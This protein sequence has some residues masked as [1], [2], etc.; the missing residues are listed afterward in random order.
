MDLT[1]LD[2]GANEGEEIRVG[3]AFWATKT[4]PVGTVLEAC[5][6]G[7]SFT[8]S[9]EEWFA[10]LVSELL[11]TERPGIWV[12][13]RVLGAESDGLLKSATDALAS[14]YLHLCSEDPCPLAEDED[15]SIH[16]TRMR[17]WT[18]ESFNADYLKR[19]GKAALTKAKKAAREDRD[20]KGR[21]GAKSKATT[22]EK[23]GPSRRKRDNGAGR[24]GDVIDIPSGDEDAEPEEGTAGLDRAALRARL[25]KTRERILEGGGRS[26]PAQPGEDLRSGPRRDSSILAQGGSRLV[27]GTALNPGQSTPL[28]LTTVAATKD[29]GEKSLM[30]KLEKRSDAASC[31]LA[32][33]VQSNQQN[34]QKQKEK[35][36]SKDKSDGLKALLD[37][38][39]GKKKKKKKKSRRRK[40]REDQDLYQQGSGLKPDPDGSGGSGSSS[41][42]GGSSSSR[43]RGRRSSSDEDSELSYEPPLRR[44]AAKEPG[45]VMK[46]LVKHAQE[47][48]DRGA[49]LEQEGASAG[50][51]HNRAE[52]FHLLRSA[53]QALLPLD[54]CPD[55]GAICLRANNRP[56][57]SRQAPGGGRRFGQ[58]VYRRPYGLSRRRM[59]HG[60]AAGNVSAGTC[61]GGIY[62]HD[63]A[64]SETPAVARQE[65]RRLPPKVDWWRRRQRQGRPLVRERPQRRRQG[66]EQGE[67]P[68]PRKRWRSHTEGGRKPLEG[69]PRDG[70][71]EMKLGPEEDLENLDIAG[72]MASLAKAGPLPA[73]G[74]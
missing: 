54:E 52:A 70:S 30:R 50:S 53:D 73:E 37:L 47:Q 35:K 33:A 49:L 23:K 27:A 25:R 57:T 64:S 44:R 60:V 39:Q 11:E 12:S 62:Q 8:F 40:D 18:A 51:N 58:S 42:S 3:D 16:V 55:E 1:L 63:A 7:S 10:V 5:T 48:M 59:G 21:P 22:G 19:A 43:K 67:G 29:A 69:Q 32:Q 68:R 24:R 74:T 71:Q 6:V 13:G 2:L 36:K 41:S 14:G 20:G 45:S 26:I 72:L 9:R 56:A 65:P 17:S 38:I 31:L 28:A 4:V 15:V 34:S 61:P 46:M 66:Q